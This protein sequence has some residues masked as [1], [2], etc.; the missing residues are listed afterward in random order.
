M[1]IIHIKQL[2]FKEEI[3]PLNIG[4][5]LEKKYE[6]ASSKGFSSL[7][8]GIDLQ[9]SANGDPLSYIYELKRHLDLFLRKNKAFVLNIFPLKAF[10]TSEVLDLLEENHDMIIKRKGAWI[11]PF[12]LL[13]EKIGSS[14]PVNPAHNLQESKQALEK[15]T[16]ENLKS[17]DD[18][19]KIIFDNVDDVVA[20]CDLDC[21]ILE[22]NK[23]GCECLGYSCD[24]LLQMPIWKLETPE[25]QAMFEEHRKLIL[26]S[27][28]A[29]FEVDLLCK[30]GTVVSHEISTW[31]IEYE[32]NLAILSIGRDVSEKRAVFETLKK[33]EEK[34]RNIFDN[35]NDAII[36]YDMKGRILEVNRVCCERTG[37]YTYEELLQ[38]SLEDLK[39]PG[40]QVQEE[41][42]KFKK[43]A[44]I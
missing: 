19:F 21:R 3:L 30:D 1:E 7:R 13:N 4:K 24:E 6:L 40:V 11:A 25:Y 41:I 15:W 32:G 28:H 14:F 8:V 20:V 16:S 12:M 5:F 22:I 37:Y 36:V 29:L 2:D 42:E 26:D 23:K 39:G 33:S 18:K 10:S 44:G 43:N 31:V 17:P 27:G 34:F 9:V 38:M 35:S